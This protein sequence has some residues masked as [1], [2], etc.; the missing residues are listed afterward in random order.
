MH[1]WCCCMIRKEA[2][3]ASACHCW[4]HVRQ[5]CLGLQDLVDE[6]GTTWPVMLSMSCMGIAKRMFVLEKIGI[7]SPTVQEQ[8]CTSCLLQCCFLCFVDQQRLADCDVE[9]HQPL[10]IWLL[11]DLCMSLNI[12]GW[13]LLCFRCV[14]AAP[15]SQAWRLHRHQANV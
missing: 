3:S 5:R 15:Q 1:E 8:A 7:C 6:S 14:L 10:W 2:Y 12:I 4:R 9:V 13:G 11:T